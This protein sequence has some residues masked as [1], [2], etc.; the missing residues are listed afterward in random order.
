[1]YNLDAVILELH[2]H[3]KICETSVSNTVIGNRTGLE[4]LRH[5]VLLL[6]F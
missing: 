6:C 1:M 3:F 5:M 4:T 2:G